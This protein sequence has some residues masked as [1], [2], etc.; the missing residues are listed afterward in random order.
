MSDTS[1]AAGDLGVPGAASDAQIAANEL[2]ARKADPAWVAKHLQGSAETRAEVE[3]LVE[4][5]HAKPGGTTQTGAGDAQVQ[6]NQ[7]ADYLAE[8][9]VGLSP[10]HIQEIR[11]GTPNSAATYDEAMRM[12]R[13]LLADPAWVKK[14]MDNDY[15]AR[16]QMLLLNIIEANGVAL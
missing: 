2:A 11:D 12:K 14:Y 15:S 3:K 7:I 4:R 10:A 9:A 1:V 8:A 13:G 6:R 5:M 16:R